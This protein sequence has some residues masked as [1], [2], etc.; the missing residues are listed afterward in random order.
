MSR[1]E[2][3]LRERATLLVSLPRN[4]PELAQAALAGGADGLKVHLNVV[5][6]ASG[7]YFGSWEEESEAI[8]AIL[9]L[10]APVGMVPG[11]QERFI[12]PREAQEIAAAGVDFV[13]AYLQDIPDWLPEQAGGMG[14]MAALSWRDEASGW[15]LGRLAG[16]CQMLEASVVPPE[17]Y[18]QPLAERD[19]AAYRQIYER[20]PKLPAIVP[21]QRSL[22][23]EEV[24]RV[25][26]TGMRGLLIGAIVTGKT[27]EGIERM[28]RE[29]AAAIKASAGAGP[30]PD[31][32]EA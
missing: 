20:H 24:A 17:G 21:T 25:L 31:R 16:R 7:T 13:D 4:D 22:R 26:A 11:T 8:R 27:A 29:F 5:H 32:K 6:H 2:A 3:L 1:T 15:D 19:L 9:A 23:P 12:T 30:P 14:V 10:G 28:T 18:G